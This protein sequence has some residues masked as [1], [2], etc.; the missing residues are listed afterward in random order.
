MSTLYPRPTLTPLI[1]WQ[2]IIFLCSK[3]EFWNSCAQLKTGCNNSPICPWL[4]VYCPILLATFLFSEVRSFILFWIARIA[5]LSWS[6]VNA[7]SPTNAL[8]ISSL[9]FAKRKACK[10]N[11]F[12][13]KST[14]KQKALFH[15][16]STLRDSLAFNFAQALA[17][18]NLLG[19]RPKRN[20]RKRNGFAFP[21][22]K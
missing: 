11:G 15:A 13:H 21:A 14:G 10:R 20:A 4:L 5:S 9:F 19:L 16:L 1:S 18:R 2:A 7:L 12:A 22:Y 3:V 17:R 6:A 8:P